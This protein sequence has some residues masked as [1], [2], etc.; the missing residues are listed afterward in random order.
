MA[1]S[2]AA[3][4]SPP[5]AAAA[6]SVEDLAS[7]YK[8][9]EKAIKD[10]ADL[11]AKGASHEDPAEAKYMQSLIGDKD[12]EREDG[13]RVVVDEF[14]IVKDGDSE[15]VV[16]KLNTPELIKEVSKKPFK[17]GLLKKY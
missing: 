10:T 4:A 2:A 8:E 5:P 7:N 6:A 15:D 3:A 9:N 13:R 17:V 1:E 12:V 11:R 16:Y 14:R